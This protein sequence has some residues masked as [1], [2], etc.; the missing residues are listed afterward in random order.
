MGQSGP[1]G[2]GGRFY[3]GPPAT[4]TKATLTLAVK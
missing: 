2:G 4:C 1:G 3:T